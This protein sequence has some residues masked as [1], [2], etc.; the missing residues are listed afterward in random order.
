MRPWLAVP[1]AAARPCMLS[2]E[3]PPL[4]PEA[5]RLQPPVGVRVCTTTENLRRL[6]RV[7]KYGAVEQVSV[8]RRVNHAMASYHGQ[9]NYRAPTWLTST[10]GGHGWAGSAPAP[11]K[12]L[13][14]VQSVHVALI[15]EYLRTIPH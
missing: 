3:L 5:A 6:K 10:L 14:A 15:G 7:E 13:Q 8:S 1:T 12:A 2:I 11:R 9:D 4:P